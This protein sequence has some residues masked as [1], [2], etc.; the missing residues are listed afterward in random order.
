MKGKSNLAGSQCVEGLEYD[1]AET[2]TDSDPQLLPFISLDKNHLGPIP[3]HGTQTE[4]V[5]GMICQ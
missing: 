4:D 3:D 5:A 2:G 1:G